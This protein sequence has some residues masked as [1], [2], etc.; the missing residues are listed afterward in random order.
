MESY[1]TSFLQSRLPFEPWVAA[2]SW[3]V[4]FFVN[5]STARLTRA[6]ND[7][8]R[9]LAVDDWS[10]VR[11]SFEPKYVAVQIIFAGIVFLLAM[12][13]GGPAYVFLAG[14]FIVAMGSS[15]TVP[16]K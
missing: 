12:Q 9:S 13:M 11:R 6:A 3:V 2:L 16:V 5:Q 14:G 4:L 1:V 7:S 15:Q 8:Q 10:A